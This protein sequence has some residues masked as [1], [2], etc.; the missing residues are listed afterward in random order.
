MIGKINKEELNKR[1][2]YVLYIVHFLH[3]KSSII[4]HINDIKATGNILILH[5]HQGIMLLHITP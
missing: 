2:W 5:E 4:T 3:I 1:T